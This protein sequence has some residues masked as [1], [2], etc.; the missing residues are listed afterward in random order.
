MVYEHLDKCYHKYQHEFVLAKSRQANFIIIIY[1]FLPSI[2][3][4]VHLGNC[5]H[6]LY[7][8]NMLQ[9]KTTRNILAVEQG[10][11]NVHCSDEERMP[12]GTMV[13]LAQGC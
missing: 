13:C 9:L 1:L 4:E 5:R 7:C 2:S 6:C 12:C 11:L 3:K 8:I 10:G